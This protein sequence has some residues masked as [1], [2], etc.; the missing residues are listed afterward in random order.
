MDPYGGYHD[1]S[2]HLFDMSS[3]DQSFVESLY[4]PRSSRSFLYGHGYNDPM[5]NRA[6]TASPSVSENSVGNKNGKSSPPKHRHDGTSPLP[7]GMD[8][9]PP[10]R[11]WVFL[12][13]LIVQ[14]SVW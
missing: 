9:S 7:L 4:N 10:P 14:L 8:W 6:A 2:L 1:Y 11:H 13:V 3:A 12:R 5:V